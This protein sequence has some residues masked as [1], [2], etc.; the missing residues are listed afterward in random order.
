MLN[1]KMDYATSHKRGEY[2][3]YKRLSKLATRTLTDACIIYESE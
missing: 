2:T 1:S 3:T